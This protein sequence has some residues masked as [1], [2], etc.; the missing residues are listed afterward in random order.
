MFAR[1]KLHWYRSKNFGD[2]LSPLLVESLCGASATYAH[3]G[4]AELIAVGSVLFG[5][6]ALFVERKKL[7]TVIGVVKIARKAF[8]WLRPTLNIW[9]TKV[10]AVRGKKTLE[11]LRRTGFVK[12]EELENIA[13]GD[14]GLLFPQLLQEK[15]PTQYDL[16]I[17]SHFRDME[18][19]VR[20]GQHFSSLGVHVKVVDVMQ[21]DPVNVLREIAQCDKILSSSL[22]GLI[23]A[24]AFQI[25]NRHI[26]F[27]TLGQTA[28]EYLFKFDDYYSAFDVKPTEC[29]SLNSVKGNELNILRMIDAVAFPQE[30]VRLIQDRLI[31]SF[32][33]RCAV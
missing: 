24:D 20:L 16:G 1:M 13:L 4:S 12:A 2:A 6:G 17:V 18:E 27:S 25:P 26:V 22:H 23:V 14:P 21:D 19:G 7:F 33:V 29:L 10:C 28:R 32:P 3:P 9:G 8:D 15:P 31:K 11:I 30:K 5:G